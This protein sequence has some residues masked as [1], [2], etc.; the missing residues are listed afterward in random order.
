M[1]DAVAGQAEFCQFGIAHRVEAGDLVR[2]GL[3]F[4][5]ARK[6]GAEPGEEGLEAGRGGER[7]VMCSIG[8][9]A[10]GI[11]RQGLLP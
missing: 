10:S 2:T 6:G 4:S 8:L 5:V 7:V 9:E 3:A 1:H 11:C